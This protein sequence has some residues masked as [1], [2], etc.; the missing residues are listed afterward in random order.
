[1]LVD[2]PARAARPPR[3]LARVHQRLGPLGSQAAEPL[4]ELL[5]GHSEPIGEPVGKPVGEFVDQLLIGHGESGEL[6]GP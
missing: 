6:P 3:D 5:A 1:M 4:S 2:P